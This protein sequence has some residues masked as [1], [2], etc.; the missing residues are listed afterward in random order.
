MG[1]G[2]YRGREDEPRTLLWQRT[3]QY[4]GPGNWLGGPEEIRLGQQGNRWRASGLL[5]QHH[6]QQSDP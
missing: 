2:A 1:Y 4:D 5:N 3:C 6:D